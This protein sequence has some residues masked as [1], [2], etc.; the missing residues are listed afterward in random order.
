MMSAIRQD[1]RNIEKEKFPRSP[2]AFNGTA[3][4]QE[5][6]GDFHYQLPRKE[7]VNQGLLKQ[8]AG[9]IMTSYVNSRR[10]IPRYVIILRDGVSESQH[11]MVMRNE[12]PAIK[13]GIQKALDDINKVSKTEIPRFAVSIVTKR[14]SHRLYQKK[15]NVIFNIPPMVAIDTEIVK[16]SGNELIFVSHCPLQGTA[17]PILVNTLINENVFNSNDELVR[18][19]AAL[20]C[21]HQKS[22]SIVSLPETIYAADEYAKRGSDVFE[23]YKIWLAQRRETLPMKQMNE[24]R[25]YDWEVITENL[26]YHTSRFKKTRIA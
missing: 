23:A 26:C 4:P 19:L 15:G 14:H 13:E 8:R 22:T 20:S 7:E 21:T 12:F 24:E 18:L 5:I 10:E 25:Q 17:Q 16:K 1:S 3:R 9:F 11:T 6:I 2:F